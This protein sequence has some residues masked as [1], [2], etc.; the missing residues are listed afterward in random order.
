[1][2]KEK[3]VR[4]SLSNSSK[5][6]EVNNI[7]FCHLLLS[8]TDPLDSS[9][10]LGRIRL[11]HPFSTLDVRGRKRRT[12]P[13]RSSAERLSLSQISTV[14]VDKGDRVESCVGMVRM[15]VSFHSGFRV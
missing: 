11:C 6:L 2:K 9:P 5:S 7:S 10:P 13:K 8:N 15:K 3:L 14:T 12:E 1:M 4:L